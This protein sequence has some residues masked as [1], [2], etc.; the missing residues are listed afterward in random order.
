[1][2][3]RP[4][5]RCGPVAL[6]ILAVGVVG[7]DRP[8]AFF[9]PVEYRDPGGRF[10]FSYPQ[11]FGDPLIGTNVGFANRVAAIRFSMFS[12][13]GVGGEAVLTRG[14]VSLDVQAAGGLYDDI[15]SEALPAGLKKKI[16]AVLPPLT[17]NN[18]CEQLGLGQH[19]DPTDPALKSL[20]PAQREAVIKLDS[21]G[22]VAPQILRCNVAGDAVTFEKESAVVADGPRRRTYGAV[23]FLTGRYSAFQ[24]I[25]AGGFPD[26]SVLTEMQA[27]VTSWRTP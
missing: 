11:T 3:L 1:M 24:L 9:Q 14:R 27:I 13:D 26:P 6:A 16:E 12:S 25:R 10:V 4:V 2:T 15:A 20:T 7:L 23:R 5:T 8:T 18:V 19:V 21:M 17:L 22:N